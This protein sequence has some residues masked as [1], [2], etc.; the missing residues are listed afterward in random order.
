MKILKWIPLFFSILLFGQENRLNDTLIVDSTSFSDPISYQNDQNSFQ[1]YDE[2]LLLGFNPFERSTHSNFGSPLIPLWWK[3]SN[4]SE[5]QIGDRLLD[6]KI[7]YPFYPS[8]F[9][10]NFPHTK[11]IYAQNYSEGQR[12]N[13]LHTRRYK[14]GSLSLDY[15]RLVS[16]GYLLHEKNKHTRFT[17]QGNFTHPKI[18]YKSQWRI[19]TFKNESEWNGGVSDDSLFL[20]GSQN[21]WELLPVNWMNLKTGIKHKGFDW[22]HSYAFSE[23]AKIEYEI[24][25]SQDS[26][27]YEGLQDDTLFYPMRLDSATAFHR[28]FTNV[29][30]SLKWKQQINEDKN[31]TLGIKHQNFKQEVGVNQWIIFTSLHS[32]FFKND[33]Y[34]AY[35]KDEINTHSFIANY[36]QQINFLGINNQ[37]KIAYEKTLPNWMK[38]NNYY[39]NSEPYHSYTPEFITPSIDQYVAW[40][41]NFGK[42]LSLHHSYHNIDNYNYFNAEAISATSETTIQVFQSRL[43]HHLTA[44]KW[45]W[46]GDA[47]YQNSSSDSI[48]LADLLLNQKVYW[49]GKVFKE[50]TE[51][52]I[53]VRALYRSAHPGMTYAPILGDFYINPLNQTN[54]SLRCDLFAN[55]QIQTIKVY[56]AYEHFNSHWQGE[57]YI[58]KP[59]PMA[60]PTFK[61]SLIW[62]FYD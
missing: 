4:S 19:H 49:Q 54:A 51:A 9:N 24:N 7:K 13:L 60:K 45:H 62:N 61:L 12:L 40:D 28:A 22:K 44:G 43:I 55:F 14:Y 27:F 52:Q 6:S 53:G 31:A 23:K 1:E 48:P 3:S 26:L 8:V 41:M 32:K 57:Q 20:S 5:L 15:D 10:Q 46:R 21:Y 38:Q 35:G 29:N 39:L 16:K 50:A 33:I 25:L 11:I 17:F 59:Y 56:V 2:V 34:I 47:A 58:L 18:P 37:F 30:H 36:K 42:N